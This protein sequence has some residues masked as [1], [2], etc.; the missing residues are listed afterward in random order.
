M[1]RLEAHAKVKRGG[2]QRRA[3]AE[4]ERSRTGKK[5][6]RQNPT[7]VV[8]TPTTRPK[9]TVRI[10][11]A[12]HATTTRLEYLRQCTKPVWMPRAR[13]SWPVTSPM[14]RTTNN[15]LSLWPSDAGQPGPGRY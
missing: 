8:D 1:Q 15:K 3:E 5:T 13:L 7:T 4:A 11:S 14:P 9:V 10:P 6:S 2:A 12:Y